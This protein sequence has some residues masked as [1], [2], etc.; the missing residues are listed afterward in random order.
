MLCLAGTSQERWAQQRGTFLE[1]AEEA[2]Q[3][4]GTVVAAEASGH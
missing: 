3:D 4:E 2:Q 1:M